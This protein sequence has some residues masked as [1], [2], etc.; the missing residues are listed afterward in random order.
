MALSDSQVSQFERDGYV[1]P[2]PVLSAAEANEMRRKLQ[3]VEATQDGALYPEQRSKSFLL[4]KW[5]NDLIRDARILDPVEQLIGPDI[6]LW[7]TIFW[8]KEAG[9]KNYVSW[10][11]DTRYWGLSSDRVVTAWIALST[12]S[13]E[14]GCMKV[15][16]G[17]H[18]GDVLN[19]EDLYHAD[20]MLTRGQEINPALVDEDKAVYMPLRIGEMS[21][22]NYRLAHASGP[23]ASADRRI[24]V[25]MHFLP[26][27][28]QQIV[29]DWDCAALVR[30][31]DPYGH[32]EAAPAPA[33][34]FDPAAVAFHQKAGKAFNEVLYKGAALNDRKL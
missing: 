30:G 11:Q 2:V 26:P 14:A 28:T 18:R 19:H 12:A 34:D 16:P 9:A 31:Q 6:L 25:S 27:E 17:T 5:L 32:F 3:A 24:G 1:S 29:G 4:F 13:V 10:H 8:I 22:H 33:R 7:N 23:N 15:L 20:N 21:L